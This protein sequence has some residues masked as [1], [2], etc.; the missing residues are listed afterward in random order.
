M[1][2]NIETQIRAEIAKLQAALVALGGA[3][4]VAPKKPAGRPPEAKRRIRRSSEQIDQEVNAV[5]QALTVVLAK[6]PDGLRSEDLQRESGFDKDAVAAATKRGL[7]SGTLAKE[8]QKRATQYLLAKA[9]PVPV[10]QQAL[11]TLKAV[12]PIRR[13]KGSK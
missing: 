5:L 11:P 4:P 8:G 2:Q 9:K 12:P 1:V 6:H 3:A 10:A 7:E 13:K